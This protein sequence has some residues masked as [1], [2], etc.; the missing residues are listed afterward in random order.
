MGIVAVVVGTRFV[1]RDS[2]R[3]APEI[4]TAFSVAN[5]R[6]P[7][8]SRPAFFAKRD[9]DQ[10]QADFVEIGRLM[11]REATYLSMECEM[12]EK[13]ESKYGTSSPIAIPKK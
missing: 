12:E 5:P 2:L 10:D 1:L 6:T 8:T 13:I 11:R 9:Q 7:T 3:C 4:S